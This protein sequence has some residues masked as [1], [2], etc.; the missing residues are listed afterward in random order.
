MLIDLHVLYF[1]GTYRSSLIIPLRVTINFHSVSKVVI[2]GSIKSNQ[3]S[4][5]V[6]EVQIQ[7]RQTATAATATTS[8][9]YFDSL[10]FRSEANEF[11]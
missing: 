10:I 5:K 6:T 4:I 1:E 9:D 11:D 7:E 2:L 8:K 3:T